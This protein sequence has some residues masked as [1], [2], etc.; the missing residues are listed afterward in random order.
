VRAETHPAPLWT[1]EHAEKFLSRQRSA[2]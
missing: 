2:P 1:P